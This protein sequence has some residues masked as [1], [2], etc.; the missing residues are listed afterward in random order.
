M[1]DCQL[2]GIEN[3]DQIDQPRMKASE[4]ISEIDRP[5]WIGIIRSSTRHAHQRVGKRNVK[6]RTRRVVIGIISPWDN[7]VDT[8]IA[9]AQENKEQFLGPI[10]DGAG[11][12]R[13]LQKG[14]N[15]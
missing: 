3:R 1:N 4:V 14:R 13:A 8:V 9:A 11:G 7:G 5:V 12:Q 2:P 10:G 15:T 6:S